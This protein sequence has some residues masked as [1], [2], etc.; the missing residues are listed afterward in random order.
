MCTLI[1]E[2]M[3]LLGGLYAIFAGK[4]KLTNSLQ[5]EGAPARIAGIF[6]VLPLPLSLAAGFLIGLLIG[7]GFISEGAL[8]AG[9]IVEIVLVLAGLGAAFLYARSVTSAA[10]PPTTLDTFE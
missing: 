4:L 1:A 6:L 10:P 2:V 5:L 9:A 3:M 7:L 8:A